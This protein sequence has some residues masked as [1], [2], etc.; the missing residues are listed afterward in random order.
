MGHLGLPLD[1]LNATTPLLILAIGAGHAVQ[2]LARYYEELEKHGDN[3]LAIVQ[4]AVS[5]GSAMLAAGIIAALSFLSL[6]MFG[7]A[8]MRTFGFFTSFGILAALLIEATLIPAVRTLATT[9]GMTYTVPTARHQR[10]TRLLS[11]TGTALGRRKVASR[12]VGGYIILVLVSIALS[13]RISV[14]TSF[15]RNFL[16]TDPIR[17]Q[18]EFLNQHF[19]GTNVLL[20][21]VEGAK[22]DAIAEPELLRGIERFQRR[23]E[24]LPGVGKSLSVVDT[25]K[26]LHHT[27]TANA[28]LPDDLPA[29]KERA[30]QYLFLYS[31]S[32]GND[33]ATR[34]T[35]DNRMAKIVVFLREDSTR[36]GDAIIA[37]ARRIAAEVFP[38]GYTLHIA[39]TLASNSA[40][41][42]T[43]VR[44]KLLNV[45]Q[46]GVIT[47]LISAVVLRSLLA[48]LFVAVPLAI[49]VMINF[50]VMGALDVRLDV[51]TSAVT[52]MAVGIGADYAVYFLFR[53][54]EE[55]A[56]DGNYPAA[57]DRAL[58]TSGKAVLFVSSAV[59]L[60]YSVLC[61]SGFRLFVQLGALVGLA[62]I[63]SS[64]ATLIVL[65]AMLT[66][67]SRTRWVRSVLGVP[68][69]EP[70]AG[71]G[72]SIASRH[73]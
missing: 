26:R 33:L 42:E 27:L 71:G 58:T 18:D 9:E 32:G 62:M 4:S 73:G 36:Y 54:R 13:G 47:V 35:P 29:T 59:G 30:I 41:T 56:R 20:L 61:L 69:L 72:Y 49:A 22:E 70:R 60:G 17:E 66:L 63:T 25:L 55:Y 1:P 37:E 48:G 14:D 21:T 15:K 24:A 19:S 12:V 40:L 3:Q 64:L 7:T 34:L 52:A 65:P 57:L 53:M 6:T 5:I 11:V 28:S 39:G 10:L 16:S 44:G 8:S 38:P 23:M 45:V 2:I 51:A 50:G 67:I 68:A 31:L 46:I 43:M